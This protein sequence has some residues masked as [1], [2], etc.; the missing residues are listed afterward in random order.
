MSET[1]EQ[2]KNVW[3]A[4]REALAAAIKAWQE[5]ESDSSHPLS[6]ATALEDAN[7]D[8]GLLLLPRS[9]GHGQWRVL[10]DGKPANF[11][12]QD[13]PAGP[14]D[15]EQAADM[16]LT[17]T[18]ADDYGKHQITVRPATD[19]EMVGSLFGD[20]DVRE[21][22]IRVEAESY[23][24]TYDR[25]TGRTELRIGGPDGRTVVID[26]GTEGHEILAGLLDRED[27]EDDDL[28]DEALNTLLGGAAEKAEGSQ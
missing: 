21:D 24:A 19:D 22:P 10:V 1:T 23:G 28:D 9:T 26:L 7:L 12:G 3:R 27:V 17:L 11:V 20:T 2:P 13:R 4:R 14:V 8:Q 5:S 18:A 16:F 15:A 6:D 25:S